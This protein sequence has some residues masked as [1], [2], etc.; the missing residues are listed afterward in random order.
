MPFKI[1]NGKIKIR[2][3]NY[4]Y[5]YYKDCTFIKQREEKDIWQGLYE[6][7]L[8]E[9]K[10]KCT[11]EE[12]LQSKEWTSLFKNVHVYIIGNAK[13]YK[14]QLTHRTIEVEFIHVKIDELPPELS[15]KY[16]MIKQ[17][18]LQSYPVSRLIDKYLQDTVN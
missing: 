18:D 10:S 17:A 9:T 6:F 5:L 1:K 4:I 8:I 14:H 13:R 7:P 12:L 2:F 16:T 3:F 15:Q 11:I